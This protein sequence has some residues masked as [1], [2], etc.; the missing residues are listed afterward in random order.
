MKRWWKFW[1]TFTWPLMLGALAVATVLYYLASRWLQDNLLPVDP[2]ATVH[3][4]SANL[5]IL[6]EPYETP[7]YFLGYL[8]IPVIAWWLYRFF[9]G[10]APMWRT[11][12]SRMNRPAMLYVGIVVAVLGTAVAAR[13]GLPHIERGTIFVQHYFQT[14]SVWHLLWLMLAK[15]LYAIRIILGVTLITFIILLWRWRKA[16]FQWLRTRLN[17][18]WISKIEWLLPILL[19]VLLFDPMFSYDR[20]HYNYVLGTVNDMVQGK[21]F[22]YETTN[23]YGVLN[24]YLVAWLFKF[25]IPLSY[26]AFSAVVMLGYFAFFIVLYAVLKYWM[27]S[28]MVALLGTAGG[29]AAYV[30]LQS[31]LD[32]TA[33]NFPGTTPFRQGWFVVVA[34]ALLFAVRGSR[35]QHPWWRRDLPLYVAAVATVWNIDAGLAVVAA[36]LVSLTLWEFQRRELLWKLRLRRIVGV[37]L[38]Q[39]LYIGIGYGAIHVI[40]RMVFGTW[41]NWGLIADAVGV[42][43]IGAGRLPLPAMGMFEFYIL[44][45]IVAAM[46]VLRRVLR[47]QSVDPLFTFFLGYGVLAFVYYIG[48]SAWSY[49]YPVSTPLVIVVT[50]LVYDVYLRPGV[51]SGPAEPFAARALVTL[52]VFVGITFAIKV[53][54]EFGKRNY[55]NIADRFTAEAN[56]ATPELLA[57]A[58]EIA[59]KYPVGT[60]VALAHVDDTQL[61]MLAKRTNVFSIYDSETV[62]FDWQYANFAKELQQQRPEYL[63]VG[64]NFFVFRPVLLRTIAPSYEVAEVWETLEVYRRKM[65]P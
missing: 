16:N 59:K 63:L 62:G 27:N 37:C 57:D 6:P 17:P 61:L 39:V 51:R 9:Q 19:A 10:C 44:A 13:A 28:R 40:N 18:A 4:L 22:L 25:V 65:Q 31:G 50:Y 24:I 41:P 7:L 14:H 48:T 36:M 64:R 38:R 53:P 29:M 3:V 15:R 47:R 5:R 11:V 58:K 45:Y 12:W 54:I 2:A 34:A 26:A 1:E 35:W 42:Y 32:R 60:R 30:Y 55:G 52:L 23:Q 8:V 21:A 20:G 43:G 33:Y 46:V 56:A 49:L